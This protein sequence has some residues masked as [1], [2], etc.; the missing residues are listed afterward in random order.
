MRIGFIGE[1]MSGRPIVERI[2]RADLHLLLWNRIPEEAKRYAHRAPSVSTVEELVAQVDVV[3][4]MLETSDD[5]SEVVFHN[6]LL[7]Q[8][9]SG[10]L[11]VDM[12]SS[13][14][15]AQSRSFASQLNQRGCE[16]LDAT[17][18]SSSSVGDSTYIMVGGSAEA[19]QKALPLLSRIG[20]PIHIGPSGSGQVAR[21]LIQSIDGA[22]V[23]ALSEGLLMAKVSGLNLRALQSVLAVGLTRSNLHCQRM[24][25][26]QFEGGT[27]AQ[28]QVK[29]MDMM[30]DVAE[31]LGLKLPLANLTRDLYHKLIDEGFESLDHTAL[32]LA[33]EQLNGI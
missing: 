4:T 24:I 1:G 33:L 21:L 14:P 22:T 16:A 13:V 29:D 28:V 31:S 8:F 11:V 26:R 17:Q 32:V 12:S 27:R 25:K 2:I 5:L 6:Q 10:Q 20:I 19:F 3:I 23:A 30:A 7:E 18:I 9:R 15:P